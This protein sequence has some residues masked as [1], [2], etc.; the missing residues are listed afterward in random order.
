MVYWQMASKVMKRFNKAMGISSSTDGSGAASLT[1]SGAAAG[2]S[3]GSSDI[4][5]LSGGQQREGWVVCG[6]PETDFREH[7]GLIRSLVR[8]WSSILPQVAQLLAGTKGSGSTATSKASRRCC[9]TCHAGLSDP[10]HRST[11]GC[12]AEV[13]SRQAGPRGASKAFATH[14]EHGHG[15][16]G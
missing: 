13:C 9:E 8:L 3:G 1:A 6:A 5:C 7:P 14:P 2:S 15:G 10:P 4:Y 12:A 11:V 16:S